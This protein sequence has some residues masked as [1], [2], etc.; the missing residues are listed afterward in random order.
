MINS[1]LNGILLYW[2]DFELC[3]YDTTALGGDKLFAFISYF[4]EFLYAGL[5]FKH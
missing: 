2:L 4:I 3:G 1:M 5:Q